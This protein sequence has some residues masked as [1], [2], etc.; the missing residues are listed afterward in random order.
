MINIGPVGHRDGHYLIFCDFPLVN[1]E[2]IIYRINIG[3]LPDGLNRHFPDR[4]TAPGI[5]L[6]LKNKLNFLI[7]SQISVNF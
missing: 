2:L 5:N 4:I 7:N 6:K 3:N 1:A